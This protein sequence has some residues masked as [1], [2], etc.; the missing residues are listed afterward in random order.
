MQSHTSAEEKRKPAKLTA[1]E[2][3]AQRRRTLAPKALPQEVIRHYPG[4]SLGIASTSLLRFF[5]SLFKYKI[6]LSSIAF[7]SF[8]LPGLWLE[9]SRLLNVAPRK[10]SSDRAPEDYLSSTGEVLASLSNEEGMPH[11]KI[12]DSSS[13]IVGDA[14]GELMGALYVDFNLEFLQFQFLLALFACPSLLTDVKKHINKEVRRRG[15]NMDTPLHEH[16]YFFQKKVNGYIRLYNQQ[17]SSSL[18]HL[19]YMTEE[20]TVA[21][22]YLCDIIKGMDPGKL[23]QHFLSQGCSSAYLPK[24]HAATHNLDWFTLDIFANHLTRITMPSGMHKNKPQVVFSWTLPFLPGSLTVCND[25]GLLIGLHESGRSSTMDTYPQP[26]GNPQF[27]LIAELAKHCATIAEI[28]TYLNTHPPASPHL[29]VVLD[30]Q[31]GGIFEILPLPKAQ[32]PSP[33]YVFRG[34]ESSDDEVKHSEPYFVATNHS[35]DPQSRKPIPETAAVSCT[36]KRYHQL[37]VELDKQLKRHTEPLTPETLKKM[38]TTILPSSSSKDTVQSFGALQ[39][40]N[41]LVILYNTSKHNAPLAPDTTGQV[42]YTLCDI[43]Q[44]AKDFL[45]H[46]KPQPQPPSTVD[47]A[48]IALRSAIYKIHRSHHALFENMGKLYQAFVN[49]LRQAELQADPISIENIVKLANPFT[50]IAEWF[51]QEQVSFNSTQL[52]LLSKCDAGLR[53]FFSDKKTDISQNASSKVMLCVGW[54]FL[55]YSFVE[56][57]QA[58]CPLGAFIAL[59]Q[60]VNAILATKSIT[61]QVYQSRNPSVLFAAQSVLKQIQAL[62]EEKTTQRLKVI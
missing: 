25:K 29:L 59:C 55:L 1:T 19:P 35:S 23:D 24:L 12:F 36:L 50:T 13:H 28:K 10:L 38:L 33:L 34:L 57:L 47:Q 42:N 37:C 15:F 41:S 54:A 44:E 14:L 61:Q 22:L 8:F 16:M 5:L 39:Q 30:P 26:G 62:P 31:G 49:H 32:G 20:D 7:L 52:E 18:L 40:E 43:A 60:S 3:A 9:F 27:S 17:R 4:T 51:S 53:T 6:D 56:L 46:P 58:D 48:F 11:I 2:I 45:T 21:T